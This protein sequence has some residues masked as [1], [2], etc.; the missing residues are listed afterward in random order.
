MI[1]GE[2]GAIWRVRRVYK[3]DCTF[4]SCPR[5]ILFIFGELLA[6]DGVEQEPERGQA[7]FGAIGWARLCET[8]GAGFF[9]SQ[10]ST[11]PLSISKFR[12]EKRNFKISIQLLKFNTFVL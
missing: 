6:T 7:L 10:N 3:V 12:L 11:P 1:V 4:R 5:S 2:L 9:D 8:L